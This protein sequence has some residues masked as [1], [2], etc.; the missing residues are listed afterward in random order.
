VV[1]PYTR[2]RAALKQQARIHPS[3][4][5]FAS[6]NGKRFAG[7]PGR[8]Q[9]SVEANAGS[10]RAAG[11]SAQTVG[12]RVDALLRIGHLR[13][14]RRLQRS[15]APL[16]TIDAARTARASFDLDPLRSPSVLAR[17]RLQPQAIPRAH[18]RLRQYREA[19]DFVP[20]LAAAS[21]RDG[22]QST[23]YSGQAEF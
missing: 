11:R 16:V 4:R 10:A 14:R 18:G 8:S 1:F 7:G 13:L 3:V 12:R 5:Q 17:G 22:T 23:G 20:A 6:R 19:T 15:G 21:P 2:K 9:A